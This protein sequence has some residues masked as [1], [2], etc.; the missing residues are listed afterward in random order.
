MLRDPPP[1]NASSAAGGVWGSRPEAATMVYF[2]VRASPWL[3]SARLGSSAGND[4]SADKGARLVPSAG[5]G[6][7]L[8]QSF[9]YPC[10]G[11]EMFSGSGP[12]IGTD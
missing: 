9:I 10:P 5:G 1:R 2:S 12:W 4:E 11:S 3:A 8:A 7:V 6:G